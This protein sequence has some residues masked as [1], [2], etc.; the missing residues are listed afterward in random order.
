MRWLTDTT[1]GTGRTTT[2]SRGCTTTTSARRWTPV[3]RH[4]VRASGRFPMG[5]RA[6]P[7]LRRPKRPAWYTWCRA[8]RHERRGLLRRLSGAVRPGAPTGWTC[9]WR[10]YRRRRRD[11]PP[12][13]G[14][15]RD[16]GP[17]GRPRAHWAA[18]PASRP[19][20]DRAGA[21]AARPVRARHGQ[22]SLASPLRRDGMVWLEQ[23]SAGRTYASPAASA[24]RGTSIVDVF[25]RGT[26]DV[27]WQRYR[28]GN[29][30]S[31][32]WV[33]IGAPPGGA[34]SAPAAIS[35]ASGRIDVFARGADYG[36]LASDLDGLVELLDARRRGGDVGAGVGVARHRAGSTCSCAAS[37]AV[38][39]HSYN[40]GA[41]WSA[42][43]P[44]GGATISAPAAVAAGASRI[45]VWAR[46][47][48]TR[49]STTCGRRRRAGRLERY[50]A[51]R[52]EAASRAGSPR[53]TRRAPGRRPRTRASR[54]R[55]RA[56]GRCPGR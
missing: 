55:R 28:N 27:I 19:G 30:W 48:A 35:N 16:V 42:W 24:R 25:M 17:P 46:G 29:T 1:F 34:T 5:H 52:A 4:A 32:G 23:R 43:T 39:Q 6:R 38:I 53:T 20:R 10:G 21:E 15:E 56:S 11:L 9:F 47:R 7:R 40:D 50:L 14:R 8:S 36:G 44:L 33:S 13:V 31:A 54:P 12:V 41:G 22:R 3:S 45:D 26:D 49:S 18:E 2:R 51:R 37:T